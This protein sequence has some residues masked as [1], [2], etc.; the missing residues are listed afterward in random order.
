MVGVQQL[1]KKIKDIT[2]E[3]FLEIKK[4]PIGFILKLS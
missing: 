1:E 3:D 4:N 2:K